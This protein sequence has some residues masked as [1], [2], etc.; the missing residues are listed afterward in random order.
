MANPP[1]AVS[2]LATSVAAALATRADELARL[3]LERVRDELDTRSN[4]AFPAPTLLVYAPVLVRWAARGGLGD[5]M[6]R[7]VEAALRGLVLQRLDQDHLIEEVMVELRRLEE[8]LLDAAA[9]EM[10]DR[11]GSAAEGL[12]VAGQLGRRISLA[13]ACAAGV[14][15]EQL[16]DGRRSD[17][18][19]LDS[20]TR[21]VSHEMRT[22]IGSAFT[23]ARML[24]EM[25]DELP[26]EERTRMLGAV[27]RG[28]ARAT[29]LLEG[30]MSLA[31]A[32]GVEGGDHL[33][34]LRDVAEDAIASLSARAEAGRVRVELA[35]ALPA[36]E[37]DGR[38]VGLVLAN[39][40]SNG[41]RF[42]DPAK[43]DRWVRIRVDRDRDRFGW[44]VQV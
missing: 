12:A 18:R 32:T 41:I 4:G 22:P 19:K 5:D 25:G 6:T 31:L 42:A 44:R 26:A 16:D 33:R 30:A 40:V 24:E 35:G 10:E 2:M 15:N 21:T 43:A 23:A 7:D 9:D 3:W 28:L 1:L 27:S 11:G 20:F 8:V 39:L 36:V 38:R 13:M 14:F 29:E 37:V 17:R 34:S